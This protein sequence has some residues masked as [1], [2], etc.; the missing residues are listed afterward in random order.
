MRILVSRPALPALGMALLLMACGG[1]STASVPTQSG[2]ISYGVIA[3][4]TGPAAQFGKLLSAPCYAATDLINAAGGPLGHKINCV[5]VDDTGDSADA[6]PNV[7]KAVATVSNFDL[8]IGL[9]S[10]TAATTVPI[11]NSAKIPLVTT[12]GLTQ[13]SKNNKLSYYWRLTPSDDANGAAFAKWAVQKGFKNAVV[14][15][16][17]DI[18]SEGNLPGLQSALPKLGAKLALDPLTI[19]ADAASYS[20]V[21]ARVIAA[22]PDVLIWS[23]D[24]QTTATFLSEYSQLNNGKIPPMVTATDSLTP[25]FFGPVSKVVGTDYVTK[26]I[27]LVGSS[28]D[29]TTPAFDT[30]KNALLADSKTHD[31]AGPLSAVG[32]PASAY[33]G[34]N[35]AA[36]AMIEAGSTVGSVYNSYFEKVVAPS[37]GAV[38]VS[39]Y[40]DGKKALAQGK[41]I[42]YVGVIGAVVFD[43][44]HNSAG[45]FAANMFTADGSAT[46]V[47]SMDGATILG[48][49]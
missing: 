4:F 8:A 13:F 39:N 18:G 19:P 34:M 27:Y 10:N 30:Y 47:G 6:V 37:S 26:D 24:P 14:V 21:V 36:L 1:S 46:R 2:D 11:V 48:L 31:I 17:S 32:P 15:F 22:N 16:Q 12:N 38:V 20:S 25:D 5:P 3:P 40:A 43:S 35:I 41:K 42:Q 33:D 28:F 49:L 29:Q 7:T 9:E 45:E 23:A 44:N